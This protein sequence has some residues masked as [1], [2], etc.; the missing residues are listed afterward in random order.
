MAK[1]TGRQSGYLAVNPR[2]RVPAM[3]TDAGIL[4]ETPA[5]LAFIA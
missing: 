4:T 5:L 1:T 3:A 2:G